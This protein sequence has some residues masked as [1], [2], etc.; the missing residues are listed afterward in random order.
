MPFR[1]VE[2]RSTLSAALLLAA[3]GLL[4]AC[5]TTYSQDDPLLVRIDDMDARLGKAERVANSQTLLDLS[6][7]IEALQTEVRALRGQAEVLENG[8]EALRKQQRDLYADLERRLSL[9]EGG[10]TARVAAAP[11]APS[12][13][14]TD[15]P[16]R[17]YGRAF[18]ALKAA[19]YPSAIAGMREFLAAHPDHELADNAQYWLGEAYYVTRDYANA[20]TAFG[21]VVQRWPESSKAPDSLVKKGY[22]QFEQRQ[23]TA[24]RQTL[25]EVGTRYPGTEAARLATERLK[26]IPADAR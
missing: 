24:A 20:A 26:R 1:A 21:R 15:A 6:Q 12:S 5:A 3:S 2:K 11:V 18:D 7:R 19:N 13:I 4:T 10:A 25:G 16:G 8:N 17:L 22:A 9:I 23:F 14:A